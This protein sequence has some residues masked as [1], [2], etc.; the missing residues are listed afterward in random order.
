MKKLGIVL[1]TYNRSSFAKES[2]DNLLPQMLRNSNRVS[3]LITDNASSDDTEKMLRP[4]GEQ[5]P[6]LI[7]YVRQNK[8]IGP[9]ANFYFGIKNIDAEYV[10][11]LGDDDI[12]CDFFISKILD[13]IDKTPGVSLI[14]FNYLLGPANLKNV[15]L[16]NG[17]FCNS[18]LVKYYN[19]AG[20]FIKEHLVGPSFISCIVF[21]K[22]SMV[23][24]MN[25]GI[26]NDCYGY[27]W[28]LCLYKGVKNE[29]ILYYKIP[30]V[31]QRC[32][33]AYRD[34]VKN[35]II[36]Q[37]N[38]FRYLEEYYPGVLNVWIKSQNECKYY[39]VFNILRTVSI[40]KDYYK[41]YK[42]ELLRS[43]HNNYYTLAIYSCLYFNKSVSRLVIQLLKVL[44]MFKSKP[45]R[46]AIMRR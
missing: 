12:I 22:E 32:G 38:L 21:K 17:V 8:N 29:M 40:Y 30:L 2:V 1:P 28:L 9:H 46:D 18:N 16:Y 44:Y 15:K 20:V 42:K 41:Q 26:Y 24:G 10:Y 3:L 36:G 35:T 13:L 31:I 19:N 5:Y 34:H 6:D 4:Y 45:Y 11:L 37:T 43:V 14:H 7:R 23:R 39:N 27:D 33:G 25:L